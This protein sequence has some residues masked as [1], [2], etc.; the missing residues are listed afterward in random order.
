MYQ[1]FPYELSMY[2]NVDHTKKGKINIYNTEIENSIIEGAKGLPYTISHLAKGSLLFDF[3]YE[4]IFSPNDYK[5]LC[6][7]YPIA[8]SLY[9]KLS[10]I[11]FSLYNHCIYWYVNMEVI[12]NAF[13]YERQ[14]EKYKLLVK[15]NNSCPIIAHVDGTTLD[16][17]QFKKYFKY[18]IGFAIDNKID[19]PNMLLYGTEEPQKKKECSAAAKLIIN[20]VANIVYERFL[21]F[22]NSKYHARNR[23][24]KRIQENEVESLV[25]LLNKKDLQK[26]YQL[27]INNKYINQIS[28]DSFC[29]CLNGEIINPKNRIRWKKS[30]S[31]GYYFFKSICNNFSI[32]ALNASVQCDKGEF[33]SNNKPANGYA[34]I[35]IMLKEVAR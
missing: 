35:D 24:V 33:D 19:S 20:S 7:N 14:I 30:K 6:E 22:L 11:Y 4:P 15:D 9:Y 18:L 27:L 31:K 25:T 8:K 5:E 32:K 26:V 23:R 34:E 3:D 29:N 10:H 16:D 2:E 17:T 12:K 28:L 1:S 13:N 21:V